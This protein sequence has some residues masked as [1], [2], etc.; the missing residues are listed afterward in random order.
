MQPPADSSGT[1]VYFI[2][3]KIFIKNTFIL[4]ES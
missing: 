4:K 3:D 1:V 2:D